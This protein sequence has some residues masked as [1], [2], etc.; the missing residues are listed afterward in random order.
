MAKGILEFD[1]NE[2]DD[3]MAHMRAVKSTDMA[4]ALF[5]LI[6]NTKKGIEH[7]LEGKDIKGE[8]VSNYEVLEMVFERIHEIL[9]DNDINIDE[10]I[11]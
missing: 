10:L 6:Y 11:N 4:S 3:K 7:E 1:L 2:F 9:N 5:E 8:Q